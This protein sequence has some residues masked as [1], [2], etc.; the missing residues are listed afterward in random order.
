MT[1]LFIVCDIITCVIIFNSLF[2]FFHEQCRC[3]A[4]DLERMAEI[5][6]NKLGVQ[7]NSPPTSGLT[8][9]RLFYHIFRITAIEL[10]LQDFYDSSIVLSDLEQRMEILA[11]DANCASIRPSE[12]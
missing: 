11:C 6:Q 2:Y 12:L 7:M 9:I 1:S 3:T 8:F 10:G 5:I 4:R